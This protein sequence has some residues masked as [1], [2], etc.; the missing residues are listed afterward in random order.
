MNDRPFRNETERRQYE[1]CRDVMFPTIVRMKEIARARMA[2]VDHVD[3]AG[4]AEKRCKDKRGAR[5]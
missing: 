1:H 3:T 2:G 4:S 5:R